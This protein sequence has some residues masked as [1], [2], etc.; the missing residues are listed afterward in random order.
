VPPSA[1]HREEQKVLAGN[2]RDVSLVVVSFRDYVDNGW[3]PSK[4]IETTTWPPTS[5]TNRH[6]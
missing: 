4:L 3:L 6:V 5:P 1:P 2:W